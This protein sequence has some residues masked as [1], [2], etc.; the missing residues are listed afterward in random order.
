[1]IVDQ[2]IFYSYHVGSLLGEDNKTGGN[3]GHIQL[4]SKPV[5][6]FLIKKILFIFFTK[7]LVC[8]K[9][10]ETEHPWS[11]YFYC[12]YP[13]GGD[14]WHANYRVIS[15]ISKNKEGCGGGLL[16]KVFVLQIWGPVFK[17]Q[18]IQ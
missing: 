12:L 11:W 15:V 16:S 8:A 10:L 2:F 9:Y 3:L 1:M 17:T 13:D 14:N 7:C 6:N 4:A 5:T 18:N